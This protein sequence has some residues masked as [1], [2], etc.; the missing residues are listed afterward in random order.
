[1]SKLILDQEQQTKVKES[2]Q[3]GQRARQRQPKDQ[4]LVRKEEDMPVSPRMKTKIKMKH[5][6][7]PR[8]WYPSRNEE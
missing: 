8:S 3:Q 5:E 2:G 1:M 6:Q 4:R 7:I